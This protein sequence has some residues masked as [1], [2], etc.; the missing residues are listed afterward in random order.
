MKMIMR[1]PITWKN[2]GK[3]SYSSGGGTLRDMWLQPLKY[4]VSTFNTDRYISFEYSFCFSCNISTSNF[5]N[6]G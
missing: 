6:N 1:R 5:N 3:M 4:S 2:D